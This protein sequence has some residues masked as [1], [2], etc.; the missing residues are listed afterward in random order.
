MP[1]LA[2]AARLLRGCGKSCRSALFAATRSVSIRESQDSSVRWPIGCT[3]SHYFGKIFGVFFRELRNSGRVFYRIHGIRDLMYLLSLAYANTRWN[4]SG[5]FS[6][7]RGNRVLGKWTVLGA[8]PQHRELLRLVAL[9][10]SSSVFLSPL[11]VPS[12]VL[13]GSG[14]GPLRVGHLRFLHD[15]V[16]TEKGRGAVVSGGMQVSALGRSTPLDRHSSR[17]FFPDHDVRTPRPKTPLCRDF[18]L[19]YGSPDFFL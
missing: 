15:G 9:S 12:R 8:H 1:R 14:K 10:C 16:D 18:L 4:G 17:R 6:L 13:C 3:L 11:S 2:W 5:R 7:L 19:A